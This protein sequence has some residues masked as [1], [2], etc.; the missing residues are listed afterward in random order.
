MTEKLLTLFSTMVG[1]LGVFITGNTLI[2]FAGLLPTII[3]GM[4]ILILGAG[5]RAI[6]KK[7][8]H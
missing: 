1:T 2:G 3:F 6:I 4:S 8:N 5:V 7:S